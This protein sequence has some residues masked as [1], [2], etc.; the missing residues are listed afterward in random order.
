MKEIVY[1]KC[2]HGEKKIIAKTRQ[3]K[4]SGIQVISHLKCLKI[5]HFHSPTKKRR[6]FMLHSLS[7]FLFLLFFFLTIFRVQVIW[8]SYNNSISHHNTGTWHTQTHIHIHI[9]S[10][11]V[12]I[13]TLQC[14]VY[15]DHIAFLISVFDFDHLPIWFMWF[16]WWSC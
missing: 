13:N 16:L 8:F 12:F 10:I 4:T 14:R 9:L 15:I 2:M 3:H 11:T 1:A 7:R 6:F 5:E